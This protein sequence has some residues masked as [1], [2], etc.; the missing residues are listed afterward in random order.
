MNDEKSR[1]IDTY[2]TI[3]KRIKSR[4]I[5]NGKLLGKMFLVSS[6]KAEHDFLEVYIQKHKNDVE[7]GLMYLV[8]E[9]LWVVKPA[10]T[11]SGEKFPVAYG[12]KQLTP[13]V[14]EDGEDIEGLKK[15]GYNII[16][17]PIEFKR[18]FDSDVIT[19]LQDLAGIA[20]PGSTSYFSYKVFSK[21]YCDRPNPFTNEILEIGVDDDMEYYQFFNPEVIPKKFKELPMAIH[22]DPSLK[23]DNTGITG[24]CY[25]KNVISDTDDGTVEKRVYAQV[26]SVGIHAPVGSEISMAKTRRFIYYLKKIGFN[27]VMISTDTFQSAEFHQILRDKGYTTQIRSMDKTPEGYH[28]LREAMVEGRIEMI[29]H[30][31]LEDEL[32]HLQRDTNSGKLDHPKEGCFTQDTQIKLTDGRSLSIEEL[33]SEQQSGKENRVY[34]INCRTGRVEHSRIKRVFPTKMVS[35][36]VRVHLDNGAV[37]RC[38]PE[39]RFMLPDG[40]FVEIQKLCSGTALMTPDNK[41]IKITSIIAIPYLGTVYDLEIEDN[42]N[43]TLEAGV[44]VHNSKDIS[45]SLAGAIWDLSLLPYDPGLSDMYIGAYGDVDDMMPVMRQ[46]LFH[47]LRE[48]NPYNF[49]RI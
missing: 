6:K 41:D 5:K 15:M 13:K 32:I 35:S 45:D 23:N 22:I 1:I 42:H 19:S 25:M 11:Y 29:K 24:A 37:I 27:I 33:L 7:S 4:F 3:S 18:D 2:N 10:T 36:L 31:K 30:N 16:Y 43:F 39:H 20:L 48:Y 46:G 28:I 38:T 17:V 34:A 12:S 26:F 40:S 9:P 21:C 47:G 44:V 14:V 8:E 49:D